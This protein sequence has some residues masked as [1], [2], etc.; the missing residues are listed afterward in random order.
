MIVSIK[1]DLLD[2]II[3]TSRLHEFMKCRIIAF[4]KI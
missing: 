1:D 2:E 4:W 3:K